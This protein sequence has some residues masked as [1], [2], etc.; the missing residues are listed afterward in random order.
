M[1]VHEAVVAHHATAM[2]VLDLHEDDLFWCTADPGWVT[3]TSYGIIAPLV[4]GVTTIVDEAD[5]DAERWYRI[6]QDQRVTV[7]YTAPTA[8]RMLMRAPEEQRKRFDLSALRLV[9]SVGEPLNP[10]IIDRVQDAWGLT[11]RDGFGQTETTAQIGNPPGQPIKPGSMGRPLPGY[12][13]V[14]TLIMLL[15]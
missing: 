5:F 7:W 14:L 4:H 8:I 10:E 6:L 13:V 2:M 11:L 1:H 12:E 3:G 15:I 9:H